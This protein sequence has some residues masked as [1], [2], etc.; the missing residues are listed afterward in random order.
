MMYKQH[1]VVTRSTDRNGMA[2]RY[3][4]GA[5]VKLARP[6]AEEVSGVSSIRISR[7]IPGSG[8]KPG[9][10]GDFVGSNF[11]VLTKEFPVR[12]FPE[13]DLKLLILL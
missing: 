10:S 13:F 1:F 11:P 2:G 7:L 5:F 6:G 9:T 3:K 12:P 4:L 8:P